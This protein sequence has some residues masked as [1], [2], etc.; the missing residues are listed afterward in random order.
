MIA[1]EQTRNMTG[2][3][4]VLCT[5]NRCESLATALE[6]AA[7]LQ[8]P[9]S[10][11]MEILVVDNNSRDCTRE[12]IERFCRKHP[13][14]FRYV[15]EPRQGLAN[16]RN[17]GIREARGE[18]VVFMDDDVT[19]DPEW[20]E[21]LAAKLRTGD[22]AGAGGRVVPEREFSAP[23]WLSLKNLGGVLALFD[24]GDLAG[25]LRQPPYGAN[26]A[27]RKEMFEKHGGFRADLGRIG[28]N[29]LSGEDTEFGR[30]L[31]DAGEHLWYEPS[32]IVYHAMQQERLK[33]E[34]FLT[35]WFAY[36]RT[37]VRQDGIRPPIL[38]I[39][40]GYFSMARLGARLAGNVGR[41]M[42]AT[43]PEKRFFFKVIVWMTI[44]QIAEGFNLWFGAKGKNHRE[45][46]MRAGSLSRS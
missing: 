39:P 33:K 45:E 41:W 17:A 25:E 15:F 6:S 2:I 35:W 37:L 31:L 43:R 13:S 3:S 11:W 38:G 4:V 20:V 7:G 27:F 28:N 24:L 44:G 42:V 23:A 30:R 32:A 12:V 10:S 5:Y 1:E 21:I 19:V 40:R 34:Y 9:E 16:A 22:W 14:R 36:G 18:I 29:L 8:V 46:A 26:M